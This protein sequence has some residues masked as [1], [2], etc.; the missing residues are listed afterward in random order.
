MGEGAHPIRRH[1]WRARGARSG[2]SGFPART[3]LRRYALALM[4]SGDFPGARHFMAQAI[5]VAPPTLEFVV[6]MADAGFIA[7]P[8]AVLAGL[9]PDA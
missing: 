5:A 8:R 7:V 4:A 2:A 9:A 1:S 3:V 6:R